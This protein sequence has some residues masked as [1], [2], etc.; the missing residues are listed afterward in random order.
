MKK[1]EAAARAPALREEYEA[2]FNL[3]A[4][5]DEERASFHLTPGRW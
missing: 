1:P 5:E 2:Q 3:A 4:S